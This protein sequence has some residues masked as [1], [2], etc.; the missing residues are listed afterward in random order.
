MR[1]LSRRFLIISAMISLVIFQPIASWWRRFGLVG[2]SFFFQLKEK[3]GRNHHGYR[4][5]YLFRV[6]FFSISSGEDG[7][8]T[9]VLRSSKKGLTKN[10][11]EATVEMRR[12]QRNHDKCGPR[13]GSAVPING[14]RNGANL[15]VSYVLVLLPHLTSFRR[16][17]LLRDH[18]RSLLSRQDALLTRPSSRSESFLCLI[19]LHQ[20]LVGFT[21]LHPVWTSFVSAVSGRLCVSPLSIRFPWCR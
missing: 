14:V 2:V 5:V 8:A 4:S 6:S 17:G 3:T 15:F 21:G 19:A 10:L 12:S 1:S 9:R 13:W 11:N 16:T 7:S 18:S 20:L